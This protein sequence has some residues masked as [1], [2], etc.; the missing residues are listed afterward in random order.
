MCAILL[1]RFRWLFYV[2]AG[3]VGLERILETAHYP[4]DVVAG[5]LLGVVGAR[6]VYLI[7]ERVFREAP[8]TLGADAALAGK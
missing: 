7:C 6:I 2:L 3:V 8:G 4:S 1:P 5:A